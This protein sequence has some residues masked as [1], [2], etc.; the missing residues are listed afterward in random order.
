MQPPRLSDAR[1]GEFQSWSRDYGTLTGYDAQTP[2]RGDT[3]APLCSSPAPAIALITVRALAGSASLTPANAAPAGRFW[4]LRLTYDAVVLAILSLSSDTDYNAP[5]SYYQRWPR[6]MLRRINTRLASRQRLQQC[7]GTV[8]RT[9][10]LGMADE[11]TGPL[12][13]DGEWRW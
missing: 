5:T 13:P 12:D 4:A 1:C 2:C 10:A 3:N 9:D 7:R 6:H 8:G 11:P